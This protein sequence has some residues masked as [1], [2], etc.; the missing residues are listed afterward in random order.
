METKKLTIE[1]LK[2][3]YEALGKQIQEQE[4]AEKA[5]REAKLKAEM[6]DR[7]NEVIDAYKRFEKLRTAYVDDYGYFTFE[8]KNKNNDPVDWLFK[9]IGL[10]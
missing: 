2:A 7:Y 3:Q 8:N 4:R 10:F 6:E 9:A 5:A 1:E